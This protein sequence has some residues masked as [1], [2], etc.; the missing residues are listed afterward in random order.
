MEANYISEIDDRIRKIHLLGNE[1][2]RKQKLNMY[3]I[4]L[5]HHTQSKVKYFTNSNDYTLIKLTH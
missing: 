2:R 3:T 4:C 1:M 5:I